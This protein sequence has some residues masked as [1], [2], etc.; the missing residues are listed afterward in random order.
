MAYQ[1]SGAFERLRTSCP[2]IPANE[3]I[4]LG[5]RVHYGVHYGAPSLCVRFPKKKRP[6][7]VRAAW[8][9]SVGEN[10][11]RALTAPSTVRTQAPRGRVG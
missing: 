6:A 10:S 2:T 11:L 8:S 7:F 5:F 1:K 3:W 9:E 4:R